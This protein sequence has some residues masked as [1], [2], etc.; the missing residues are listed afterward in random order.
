MAEMMVEEEE[1]AGS[2]VEPA[3]LAKL[4]GLAKSLAQ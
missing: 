2:A 3:H 4:A 1:G